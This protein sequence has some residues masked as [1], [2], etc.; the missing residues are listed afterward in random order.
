MKS[1]VIAA[2]QGYKRWISPMLPNACRFVPTC[3][4]YAI[5]AVHQHGVLRGVAMGAWRVLRC[6]PL[7]GSGYDPV[8]DSSHICQSQAD[9]GH[10]PV[11]MGHR[12]V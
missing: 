2:L 12:S 6:N 11:E 10:R 8:R 4:E 7:G 5:D 9:M 1:M 3:S